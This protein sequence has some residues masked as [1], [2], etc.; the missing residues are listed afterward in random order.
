MLRP[1]FKTDD[2]LFQVF[3]VA[4]SLSKTVEELLYGRS[5]PM[6]AKEF[7]YWQAYLKVKS[8]YQKEH[9]KKNSG[10]SNKL[11]NSP[12]FKKTMGKNAA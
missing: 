2:D 5:G 12:E 7:V 4:E 8:D 9:E 1:T 11:Q 3:F 10:K 6:S